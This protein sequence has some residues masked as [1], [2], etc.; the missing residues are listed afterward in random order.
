MMWYIYIY[1]VC[2][3]PEDVMGEETGD[4]IVVE[5]KAVVGGEV[6]SI[7]EEQVPQQ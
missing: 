5:R 6:G 4:D 1:T 3:G 7:E 2:F